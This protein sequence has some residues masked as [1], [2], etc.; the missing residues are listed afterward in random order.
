M[1]KLNLAISSSLPPSPQA[2]T[3]STAIQPAASGSSA[4]P[5]LYEVSLH[6]LIPSS[7]FP[8]LISKLN[9]LSLSS[10]PFTLKETVMRPIVP[11]EGAKAE[12]GVIRVKVLEGRR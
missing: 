4:P 5:T 1:R 10:S 6:G 8:P 7:T 3:M 12:D 11:P 2:T 9:S